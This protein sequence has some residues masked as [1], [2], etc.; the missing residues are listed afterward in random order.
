MC[1]LP[2]GVVAIV[3]SSQVNNKIACGD[4]EGA[5]EASRLAKIWSWWSVGIMV[6][7]FL[8]YILFEL[9]IFFGLFAVAGTAILSQ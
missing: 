2:L 6:V 5:W 9:L 1:C 3:Y 4:I 8:L 7:S